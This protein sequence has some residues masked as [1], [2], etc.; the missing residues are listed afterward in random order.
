MEELTQTDAKLS[1]QALTVRDLQNELA[2]KR[3]KSQ[4]YKNSANKL[5][6]EIAHFIGSGVEGLVRMLLSCDEFHVALTHVAS[7]AINYGVERGLRAKADFD[8][9]LVGFPTTLFPFLGKVVA[10]ARG[11]L[12]N[13]AHILPDKFAR[14]STSVS[15]VPYDV[16]EAPDQVPL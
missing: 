4:G 3:S 16:N 9:A 6:E 1:E 15:V 8:K 5:R 10:V 13:V 12:F 7:L 2:L 11:T 14:S